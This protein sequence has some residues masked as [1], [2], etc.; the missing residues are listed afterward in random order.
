VIPKIVGFGALR[1]IVK[2]ILEGE[3]SISSVS[4]K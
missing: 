4:W 2:E 3:D 1:E